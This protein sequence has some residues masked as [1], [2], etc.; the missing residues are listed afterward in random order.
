MKASIII[1]NLNG[2]GWLEDS[3]R[4]CIN[5]DFDGEYEIIVIDN[6]STDGSM[7]IIRRCAQDFANFVIIANEHNTGFAYAVNQGIKRSQAEYAV[8]F[9]NDAFA[10]PDWLQK[11]VDTADGDKNIFSVGGLM[12]QHFNRELADDAGD[13]VPLFGWTCK[14]GDGL[15]KER[16][17]K[18]ERVFS[19][20]GGAA[21]Y[22]RSILDEIGSF[23][24]GFFAYGEDV[25]LGWRGNNAG[26]KNIYNP[27]AVC[28]HICSATTGGR[29]NDFKATKSGQNNLLLLYKNQPLLMLILNF[30]FQLIGFLPKLVMYCARGYGKP[31]MRGTMQG[32][33]MMKST[34]KYPF[35]L[36]N[37][38]GYLWVEWTMFKH[39]FTYVNYRVRRFLKKV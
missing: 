35:K 12:V 30:P 31:F 26:Y 18:T 10:E 27:Q 6:G 20:C 1:P 8:M 32:I 23:D 34:Q 7:D 36:K 16:Y 24:E 9:N 11:L 22:R 14:R 19:N 37:L 33:K 2:E 25:D 21:L 28:Y 5:Q 3:I 17:N 13:Y 4:S 15:K 38:G 29:Y 39:C